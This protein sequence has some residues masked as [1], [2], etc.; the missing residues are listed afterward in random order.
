[1]CISRT[2]NNFRLA[3]L[4]SYFLHPPPICVFYHA[5]LFFFP[6]GVV[7]FVRVFG[8]IFPWPTLI[9]FL[10]LQPP[11]FSTLS[12]P[13]AQ[14][15]PR[16]PF[17]FL[18]MSLPVTTWTTRLHTDQE[19]NGWVEGSHSED[20]MPQY[21]FSNIA[22][23][24]EADQATAANDQLLHDM[25]LNIN[26]AG[27]YPQILPLELDEMAEGLV[28]PERDTGVE[29]FE[30]VMAKPTWRRSPEGISD[31]AGTDETLLPPLTE[32]HIAGLY[33]P[34]QHGYIN[35]WIPEVPGYRDE[36]ASVYSQETSPWSNY[37]ETP[38]SGENPDWVNVS[39]GSAT[40]DWEIQG[41]GSRFSSFMSSASYSE[42][43]ELD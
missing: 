6:P 1:M 7:R 39:A 4:L 10:V 25:A 24:Q 5:H 32:A 8:P 13:F 3:P 37:A 14:T 19:K 36:T 33:G 27:T 20:R 22:S 2:A 17:P 15:T 18:K 38:V 23:A 34:E 43:L 28:I 12:I 9:M 31:Q 16:S 11:A 40:I 26:Y 42:E 29:A 41:L 35:R 30:T 21:N